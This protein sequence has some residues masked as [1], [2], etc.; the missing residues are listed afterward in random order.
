MSDDRRTPP[1]TVDLMRS[2][3]EAQGLALSHDELMALMPLV[4]IGRDPL[5]AAPDMAP[6][7]E[8]AARFTVIS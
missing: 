3:A 7:T 2:I 8:P 4:A 6:E 5:L 1:L